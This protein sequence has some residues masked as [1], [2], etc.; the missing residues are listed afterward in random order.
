MGDVGR[1]MA[2]E[3]YMPSDLHRSLIQNTP[4]V[5]LVKLEEYL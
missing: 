4:E 5:V 3:E 2:T 1:G